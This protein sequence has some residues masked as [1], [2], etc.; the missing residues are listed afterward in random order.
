ME[1][2]VAQEHPWDLLDCLSLADCGVEGFYLL[3]ALVLFFFVA[4]RSAM[5]S[6]MIRE[7]EPNSPTLSQLKRNRSVHLMIMIFLLALILDLCLSVVIFWMVYKKKV[8][9]AQLW[10]LFD[11][12]MLVQQAHVYLMDMVYITIAYLYYKAI[13]CLGSIER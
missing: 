10:H 8:D 11:T 3:L 7:C 2:C 13:V 9:S 6:G 4:K 5:V 12:Y 1:G